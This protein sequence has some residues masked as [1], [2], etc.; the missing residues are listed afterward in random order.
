MFPDTNCKSVPCIIY[1]ANA[2]QESNLWYCWPNWIAYKTNQSSPLPKSSFEQS[3][4][5]VLPPS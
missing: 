5:H 2:C 3:K 4:V 1:P